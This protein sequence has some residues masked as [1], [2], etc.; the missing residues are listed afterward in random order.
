MVIAT[1]HHPL[2]GY[3]VLRNGAL[4]SVRYPP[5]PWPKQL[6]NLSISLTLA[7]G[8]W[9]IVPLQEKL[10]LLHGGETEGD[11]RGLLAIGGE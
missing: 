1:P 10:H 11:L 5:Q 7:D 9:S 4:L 8:S 6:H 3:I 2:K